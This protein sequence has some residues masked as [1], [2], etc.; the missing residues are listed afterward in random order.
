MSEKNLTPTST[1]IAI[2]ARLGSSRLPEKVLLD[3]NKLPLIDHIVKQL[4]PCKGS[5]IVLTTSDSEMDQKLVRH[6]KTQNKKSYCGPVDDIIGRLNGVLT[7]TSA[8]YLVRIWGDCPF[9]SADIVNSMMSFFLKHDLD[10][11]SNSEINNRT[12]PP[13]LDVEIYSRNLLT[14]M[15]SQVTEK[16]LREFPIEY[17][18]SSG[19]QFKYKYFHLKDFTEDPS[20]HISPDLHLTIDYKDDLLATETIF[21][22]LCPMNEVFDFPELSRFAHSRPDLFKMFSKNE[23]NIEYKKYLKEKEKST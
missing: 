19:H 12:F 20:L 15:N 23:R 14:S 6:F 18:K 8:D 13:G 4:S 16:S 22:L 3:I 9:I 1:A 21:Q 17:V 11:L 5:E 2:Q 10:F 7:L